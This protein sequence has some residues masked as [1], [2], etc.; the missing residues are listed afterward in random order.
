MAKYD[1][2]NEYLSNLSGKN[3]ITLSFEQVEKIIQAELP[4][5][6][7]NHRAWWSNEEHGVH[8]SAKAWMGAGWRVETVNQKDCWVKFIRKQR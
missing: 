5:S 2:L 1:P 6:A 4:Y 8:V 3:E 7:Y